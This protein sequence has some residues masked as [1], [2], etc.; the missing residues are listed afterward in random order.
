MFA[1]FAADL[2]DSGLGIERLFHALISNEFA[3]THNQE[4]LPA[5]RNLTRL[6][7]KLLN[8]KNGVM[9]L[10]LWLSVLIDC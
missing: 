1:E 7:I 5:L 8:T 9:S 6:A 4:S 3:V 2:G 10:L